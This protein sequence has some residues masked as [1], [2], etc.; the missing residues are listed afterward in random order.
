MSTPRQ[1]YPSPLGE[2]G[3]WGRGYVQRHPV[4]ALNTVGSQCILGLQAIR[5]LIVDIVRWR[6]PFWEFVEQAAFMASTAMLPTMCVAIPIGVTLQIQFALLA[7]QVGATSLAGAASGLA[8][9]RQ[10][11]P[12]VAAL[13]MASAVGSAICADLGSRTIREEVDALEVLGIS[14]VRRLVVPRLAAAIV[15]GVALT[16]LVCFIGFLAGYLFNTFA[17]NGAPGSFVMTFASF[18]TVGDLILT[19]IKAVVFA[20][21]VAIVACDK[22]LTTKGG[23]AGVANSVN[24]TVVAS[25]LLLMIT[26]V[27]FTQMYVLLFPKA[28][29]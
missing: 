24:A 29:L 21:I 5:Y 1:V 10:G 28:A 7:G 27:V 12:L 26:N 8:V 11:A 14:A 15:V 13:L 6:F 18:A 20:A 17:Q 2:V 22:G 19:L 25:I 16:G 9:I 4:A 3:D 23:P